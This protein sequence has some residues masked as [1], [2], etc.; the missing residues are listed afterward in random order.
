[1]SSKKLE[2]SSDASSTIDNGEEDEGFLN[3]ETFKAQ[4][5]KNPDGN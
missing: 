4:L 2:A 5:K 1:M 3:E